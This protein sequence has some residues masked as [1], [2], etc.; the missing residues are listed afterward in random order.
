MTTAS[1]IV[2]SIVAET[3]RADLKTTI[4]SYLQQTIRECH[5]DPERNTA[6]FLWPNY[7]EAQVTATAE[8]AF[9]WQIPNTTRYQGV[10]MVR[11]DSVYEDGDVSFAMP[12]VPGRVG[13]SQRHAFQ[14]VGDR[15]IF[16]GYGGVGGVIS[17]AYFEFPRALK[18]YDVATRPATWDDVNGYAYHADYSASDALKTTARL[19]TTNWLLERWPMVLEEGLRAK[20]YKRLSDTERARTCYSLYMQLRLGLQN[21]ESA[22]LAGVR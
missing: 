2:D 11:Y 4:V 5:I 17:I 19:L 6:V 18:Y 22:D 15:L 12:L 10:Q 20:I 7:V 9:S 16:K 21:S 8:S 1:Q 3:S 13:N 14:Q